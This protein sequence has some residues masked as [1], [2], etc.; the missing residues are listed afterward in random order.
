[1]DIAA[2]RTYVAIL[3]E[4]SFSGA[5]LRL[6]ISKSLC[7]KHISDLEQMLGLRLL[8]RTTRSVRPTDAGAD[9]GEQVR[10]VLARLDRANEA[11]RELSL[12]PMG[13]LRIAAPISYTLTILQPH[14]LRFIR[15]FPDIRMELKMEDGITDLI[16]EGFDAVF[17]IGVLD[18]SALIARH[19]HDVPLCVVGSPGYLQQCGAP[20]QPADLIRHRCLHYSNARSAVTWGFQQD[21][22]VFHQK[23]RAVF[24]S[25]NGDMLR[26]MAKEGHG[27]A[28]IPR[29]IVETELADG[30]LVPLLEDFTMQA[31]PVNLVYPS[32]R[33]TT[34]AMRSFLDFVAGLRLDQPA[35]PAA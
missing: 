1:M 33:L 27:L 9:Y 10:E 21:G 4:G 22:E 24:A 20:E 3:D 29:F 26:G 2:L 35:R 6:G 8:V 31:L 19:L 15:E 13:R 7:S 5:A 25:N 34:A 18:D 14:L 32:R 28:M 17:R 16:G 30:S 11:V 12:N 23:V